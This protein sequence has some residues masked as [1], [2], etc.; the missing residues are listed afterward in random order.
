M[1]KSW[2]FD[3]FN[4]PYDSAPEGL[5]PALVEDEFDW[6]LDAWVKAE[7]LG[8][9]GVLFSEHHFT[10]YNMSPSPNL[11][12]AAVAQ[13]TNTLRLGAMCNVTAFHNPRRLAE[14]TAMLDYLTRGRLEVGLGRG[15]DDHE[16]RKE[17]FPL[18]DTRPWF[19]ESLELMHKAWEQPRFTHHGRFFHYDDVSI[20]P[21]PR[22]TPRIW[23][24]AL[25]PATI[26]WA[27]S[28]GYRLSL[29]FMPAKVM[30][31]F[32]NIYNEAAADAGHSTAPEQIGVMRN[33]FVADSDEEA[34]DLAEPALDHVFRLFK[35]AAVPDDLGHM[36]PGYE[37]YSSFFAPFAAEGGV[38]FEDLQASGA[39]VVGSPSTVRDQLVAQVEEIGCG[40]LM[41]WF[42]FG[43]LTRD[44]T[45][46]S[47]ELYAK[48][49]VPALRSLEVR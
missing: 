19:E 36:A 14:E 6:H 9:D 44:Q 25:S 43:Q 4:Y 31:Q 22:R 2:L 5:D 23:V 49:I 10:A 47:M 24:T 45:M 7:E 21:R 18:E 11:L 38:R 16:F 42:S 30:A 29:A 39:V 28:K 20:Y 34:R 17:G 27:G 46:R 35:E 26:A 3:I 8:Y 13:R 33:I 41:N 48:E 32:R 40:H 12:V 1:V 37:G 15:A